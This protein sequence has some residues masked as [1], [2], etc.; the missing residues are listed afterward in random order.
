MAATPPIAMEEPIV[1]SPAIPI[2]ANTVGN[3]EP[4][5]VSPVTRPVTIVV[6]IAFVTVPGFTPSIRDA[7]ASVAI[8]KVTISSAVAKVHVS[9]TVAEIHVAIAIIKV[10]VS[11][12]I[13]DP[14]IV[15]V[16]TEA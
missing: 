16:S 1:V 13:S 4:I 10:G 6:S 9:A 2:T 11:V 15:I 12:A 7:V 14:S 5:T 3:R 8:S